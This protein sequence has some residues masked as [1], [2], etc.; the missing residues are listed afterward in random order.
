MATIDN[1]LMSELQELNYFFQEGEV[2]LGWFRQSG[3]RVIIVIDDCYKECRIIEPPA[4]FAVGLKPFLEQTTKWEDTRAIGYFYLP[5]PSDFETTSALILKSIIEWIDTI[6]NKNNN[7]YYFLID[8]YHA[9]NETVGQRFYNFINNNINVLEIVKYKIAFLSIAGAHQT[10]PENVSAFAKTDIMQVA[11]NE[12]YGK[13]LDPKLREWLGYFIKPLIK[14]WDTPEYKT[15][16]TKEHESMKHEADQI[17][18][19]FYS[20]LTRRQNRDDIIYRE[21]IEEALKLEKNETPDS[22]WSSE[23]SVKNIH[24]SFKCLCGDSSRYVNQQQSRVI[25]VGAAYLIALMACKEVRKDKVSNLLI[26]DWDDWKKA[27]NFI[28]PQQSQDVARETALCLYDLFVHLFQ[29]RDND[30][31]SVKSA[32]FLEEGKI[33]I[34]EFN[35]DASIH[36]RC[37][38][39]RFVTPNSKFDW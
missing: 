16:F 23:K 22:W 25:S 39:F 37:D 21:N 1:N 4:P 9:N 3:T 6:R 20:N 17:W 12:A 15:W 18:D 34:F 36:P 33:L 11:K 13:R 35:W 31:Y 28:V 30:S 7:N 8:N 26:S 5:H 2:F 27:T 38:R 24:E 14:L 29:P 32:K 10:L 19:Y